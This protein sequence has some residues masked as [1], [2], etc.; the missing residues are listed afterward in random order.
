MKILLSPQLTICGIHELVMHSDKSVT[1]VLSIID[2]ERP[3]LT[4]FSDFGAHERTTLRFH[5]II[6]D[7]EGQILPSQEH[8]EAILNFGHAFQSR[9]DG[10]TE[11]H[12]L[13]HCHMG[14]SR[15]TAAMLTLMAQAASDEPAEVLFQRLAKVRPQA[16]PNS[17]MVAFADEQ[18]GRGGELSRE[19]GYHYGRQL[20]SRREIKDWM[21]S[22][23]R[24]AEVEMAKFN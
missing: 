17:R 23:G 3:D 19:L 1:H 11:A 13:V 21:I 6:A 4:E 5:D 7:I 9:K 14:V 2:P 24:G 15:S 8:T 20:T 16:W 10:D 18:L 12:I 22:L